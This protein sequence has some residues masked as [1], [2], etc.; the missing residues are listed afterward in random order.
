MIAQ[1]ANALVLGSVL[2]LF[3]LSLS[4]VRGI[5]MSSIWRSVRCSCSAVTSH[6][7][8]ESPSPGRSSSW[9]RCA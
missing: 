8:S 7:A 9:S 5:W 4:L 1:L 6:T 2:L 3:S